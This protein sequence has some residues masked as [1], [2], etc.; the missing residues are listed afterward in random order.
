MNENRLQARAKEPFG[1][2]II[3]RAEARQEAWVAWAV[4]WMSLGAILGIA[5]CVLVISLWGKF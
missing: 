5:G 3:A 4:F 2:E 1:A